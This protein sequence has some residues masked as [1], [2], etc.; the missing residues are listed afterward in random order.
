VVGEAEVQRQ[1]R[2][3]PLAGGKTLGGEAC[4][5]PPRVTPQAESR[6][7]AEGSGEMIGGTA[8]GGCQLAQA[9]WGFEVRVDSEL[10]RLDEVA[11]AAPG[12]LR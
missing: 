9:G 6:S 8:E 2:E 7:L 1:T 10:H 11:P 4:P 12:A 5:E 3:V